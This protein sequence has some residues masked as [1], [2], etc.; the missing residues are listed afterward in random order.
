MRDTEGDFEITN[1]A[2][3][4]LSMNHMNNSSKRVFNTFIPGV[5]LSADVPPYE[6]SLPGQYTMNGAFDN[7]SG[8]DYTSNSFHIDDQ[9][10]N[11]N[12]ISHYSDNVNLSDSS[13]SG[14]QHGIVDKKGS[15]GNNTKKTVSSARPPKRSSKEASRGPP[16]KVR[17]PPVAVPSPSPPT[18]TVAEAGAGATDVVE[19]SNENISGSKTGRIKKPKSRKTTI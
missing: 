15:N 7:G 14:P 3:E 18:S 16:A 10:H 8:G 12:E 11:D 5:G 17:G 4:F 6:P 2:E 1:V 13:P 19:I 9:Y